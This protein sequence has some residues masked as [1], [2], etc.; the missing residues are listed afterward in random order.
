VRGFE[1]ALTLG[2]FSLG[3]GAADGGDS[4]AVGAGRDVRRG[5]APRSSQLND[6]TAHP[7]SSVLAIQ[8]RGGHISA[9]CATVFL[10]LSNQ[11]NPS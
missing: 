7:S 6:T 2:F 5:A 9:T 8:T 3:L 10:R 1:G 11:I 4:R